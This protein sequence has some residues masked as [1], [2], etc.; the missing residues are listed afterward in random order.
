MTQGR[1]ITFYSAKG[2][3]GQTLISSNLA[4][5]A[6][7]KSRTLIVQLTHYPDLHNIFNLNTEKH[8][9]HVLEF[10]EHNEK[11]T[12]A[13]SQLTYHVDNLDIL[14]SP[15]GT[16]IITQ[17]TEQHISTLLDI[18]TIH[19]D[20]IYIDLGKEFKHKDLILKKSDHII[21]LTYVDPQSINKTKSLIHQ[22]KSLGKNIHIIV[23]QA[24]AQMNLKKI[25]A[26][27]EQNS[28]N[29]IGILPTD[30]ESIWDN[31]THGI[32]YAK[33]MSKLT[34]HTSKLLTAYNE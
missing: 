32:P 8:L 22:L 25:K 19:Y 30:C 34:K 4:Y 17:V 7:Q 14:L 20:N 3:A 9:L 13:L 10:L 29:I 2:G 18:L 16:R 24:P 28:M 31:L 23:N 33:H 26:C 12:E 21:S 15:L 5:L 11:P 27:F 6:S 1:I